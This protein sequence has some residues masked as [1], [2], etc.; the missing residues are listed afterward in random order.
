MYK[1]FIDNQ[2][3]MVSQKHCTVFCYWL[4]AL[5]VALTFVSAVVPFFTAGYQLLFSVLLV[6]LTPYIIYGCSLSFLRQNFAMIVGIV[7][8]LVHLLLVI[9]ERFIDTADYSDGMI[10][11]LPLMLSLVLAVILY[12]ALRKWSWDEAEKNS[13][14]EA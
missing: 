2:K 3:D 1:L 6:G 14:Q 13:Q 4:I 11:Y 9:A 7:L 5:G 10:Y 8:L 12:L